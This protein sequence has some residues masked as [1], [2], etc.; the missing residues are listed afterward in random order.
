MSEVDKLVEETNRKIQDRKRQG[1]PATLD[2]AKKA[3]EKEKYFMMVF[4]SKTGPP[5]KGPEDSGKYCVYNS[6]GAAKR[7]RGGGGRGGFGRGG[8][9]GGGSASYQADIDIVMGS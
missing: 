8:G 5:P 3:K 1:R 6:Q 2:A 9:G 7:G 4:G